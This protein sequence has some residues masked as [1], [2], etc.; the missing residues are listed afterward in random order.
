MLSIGCAEI[1]RV[2][3]GSGCCLVDDI[4]MGFMHM[5]RSQGVFVVYKVK[6]LGCFTWV[7]FLC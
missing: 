5:N 2:S 6:F 4:V 1:D 7:F 3:I